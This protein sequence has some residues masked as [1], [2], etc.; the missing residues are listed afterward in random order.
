[1]GISLRIKSVRTWLNDPMGV[2]LNDRVSLVVS[3]ILFIFIRNFVRF[4]VGKKKREQIFEKRGLTYISVLKKLRF[5][6]IMVKN[7]DGKFWCRPND[8]DT[9]MISDK[10]ENF[11]RE[12]LKPNGDDIGA[13]IGK[14]AIRWARLGGKDAKVYAVEVEPGTYDYLCKNIKLNNF[15]DR[16][17]PLKCAISNKKG[18]TTFFIAEGRSEINSMRDEW[19]KKID[20]DTNTIDELVK[21]KKIEK[22]YLI[23][24]D[25]QGAEYEAIQGAENSIKNGI[26]NKFV[27]ETHGSKNF[28]IIPPLLSSLYDIEVFHKTGPDFGYLICKKK[29]KN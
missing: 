4:L 8:T 12:K 21:E 3:K 18:K 9:I 16:I 19:G 14:Y 17:I 25:I 22:I 5:V 1:M 15:E 29:Q 10:H 6:P 11:L 2:R 24:M 26:I 27:I 23:Q 28:K 13:H 7:Q 20:V